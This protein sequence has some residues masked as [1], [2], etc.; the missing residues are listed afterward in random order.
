MARGEAAAGGKPREATKYA[1]WA[2]TLRRWAEDPR[3]SLDALPELRA[4][5]YSPETWAR[6]LTHVTA[7]VDAAS[8]RWHRHLA[9]ALS[10]PLTPFE[11]GRE[12]VALRATLARRNQICSHPSLPSELRELLSKDMRQA[13]EKY[14]QDLEEAVRRSTANASI[15]GDRDELWRTVRQNSFVSVLDFRLDTGSER[16]S[17]QPLP[18]TP[19]I[20]SAPP[21]RARRRVVAK[22]ESH[23]ERG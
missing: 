9:Q 1:A 18:E 23:E 8:K 11:L 3:T 21:A 20:R 19:R 22:P 14:Q 6:L 13:V 4:D 5:D 17:A 16:P 10:G 2:N 15:E 12:L 7:A